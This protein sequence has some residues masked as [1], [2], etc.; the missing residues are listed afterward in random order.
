MLA[1]NQNGHSYYIAAPHLIIQLHQIVLKDS[2]SDWYGMSVS[3][4]KMYWYLYTTVYSRV[5]GAGVF[6]WS[7][8]LF[9]RIRLLLLLD[10]KTCYRYFYGT[11]R[12]SL[13]VFRLFKVGVGVRGQGVVG[14]R[15]VVGGRGRRVVVGGR[16]RRGVVV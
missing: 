1:R 11:L 2:V 4:R 13:I 6:G 14:R 7:W 3:I 8:S 10:C 5:A 15:V 12:L 9:V 16:G